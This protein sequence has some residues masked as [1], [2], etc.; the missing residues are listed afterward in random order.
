MAQN[1]QASVPAHWDKVIALIELAKTD[2]SIR[3]IMQ[4]GTAE[5][6]LVVLTDAGIDLDA[7]SKTVDDMAMIANLESIHFWYW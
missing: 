5:E 4:S 1:V 6:K 3:E 2:D 7:I